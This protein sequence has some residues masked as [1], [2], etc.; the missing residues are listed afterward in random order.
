MRAEPTPADTS[1][2]AWARE[3]KSAQHRCRH[4]KQCALPRSVRRAAAVPCMISMIFGGSPLN[5]GGG[6]IHHTFG[7]SPSVS[8]FANCRQMYGTDGHLRFVPLLSAAGS[9]LTQ[10]VLRCVSH[11]PKLM[12]ISVGSVLNAFVKAPWIL[13]YGS[14]KY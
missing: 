4:F 8:G 10:S 1:R 13:V 3:A 14:M 9:Q 6:V 11:A 5:L 12:T 7:A 2:Q